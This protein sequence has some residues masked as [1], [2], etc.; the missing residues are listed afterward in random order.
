MHIKHMYTQAKHDELNYWIDFKCFIYKL[1][2]ICTK[3]Y[4]AGVSSIVFIC[5]F[6]NLNTVFVAFVDVGFGS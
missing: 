5:L 3:L 2:F 4:S 1:H 6:I